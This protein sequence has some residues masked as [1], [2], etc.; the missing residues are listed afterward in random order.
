MKIILVSLLLLSFNASSENFKDLLGTYDLYVQI[1]KMQ[2]VDIMEIKDA[3]IIRRDG[4]AIKVSYTGTFEVPGVFKS[5][6]KG[7]AYPHQSKYIEFE[8]LSYDGG[9]LDGQFI[10]K[11][12]GHEFTVNIL[13][14]D[15]ININKFT[16][17]LKTNDNTF[18]TFE[19]IKRN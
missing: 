2:F 7:N 6:L 4:L 8:N 5:E 9:K 15:F 18:G 17:E 13:S 19:A 10:A 3:K 11:E 12:N 14:K 1:G 16:G